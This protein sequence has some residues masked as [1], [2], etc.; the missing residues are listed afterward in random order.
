MK[1]QLIMLVKQMNDLMQELDGCCDSLIGIEAPEIDTASTTM[2][3]KKQINYLFLALSIPVFFALVASG[4]FSGCNFQSN[5]DR[6]YQSDISNIKLNAFNVGDTLYPDYSHNDT[7]IVISIASADTLNLL[8]DGVDLPAP[9][10][11][12]EIDS[13]LHKYCR[14][15]YHTCKWKLCPYKGITQ[16]NFGKSVAAYVGKSEGD[17]FSL[18]M[19]HLYYPAAEYEELE[20]MLRED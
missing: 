3:Q 20:T 2:Q 4:A 17:G 6:H 18:D 16:D 11:D 7:L 15:F 10:T 8:F 1:E 13:V 19:L 5:A 9:A 12:W 14:T